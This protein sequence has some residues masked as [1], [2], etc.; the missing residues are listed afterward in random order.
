MD[1]SVDFWTGVLIGGAVVATV[2]TAWTICYR[3]TCVNC[4]KQL[5]CAR[6]AYCA[7]RNGVLGISED[8]VHE[9]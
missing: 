9:R 7:H 1:L 5:Y 3:P 6:E 4:G 8:T 2:M